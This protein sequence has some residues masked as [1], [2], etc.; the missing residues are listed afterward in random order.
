MRRIY[1]KKTK[2]KKKKK[3]YGKG[4]YSALNKFIKGFKF[5]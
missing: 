3:I 5:F 4:R 2:Y 1:V